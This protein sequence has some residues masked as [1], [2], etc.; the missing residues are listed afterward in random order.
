LSSTQ[1]RQ[2]LA[3]VLG[4]RVVSSLRNPVYRIY[5]LGVL[6]QFASMS[7]QTVAGSLLMYRLTGSAAL[8]GMISLA[9]AIPMIVFS[10]FGGAIADR[11]EKKYLL[12]A[13]LFSTFLLALGIGLALEYGIISQEKEGSWWILVVQS[14][15]M[16]CI[17][18]T[19][20]PARQAIIPEIVS[21]EQTMNAIALN[22]LA[23]NVLSLIGPAIAGFLADGLGFASVYFCMAGF[24]LYGGIMICFIPRTSPANGHRGSILSDIFEG[25]EYIKKDRRILFILIFTTLIVVLSMPFSQLLP[26]FTDDILKVGATGLGVLMSVSGAGALVGSIALA[27]L[28]NKKRGMLLLSAGIVVGAALLVFAFSRSM[29]LSMAFMIFIGLGQTLRGTVGSALLQSYTEP[30]YMGRVMSILMMQWGVMSLVTFGAG[31][32]AEYVQVQWVIGSLSITLLVV[33]L[34]SFFTFPKIRRLD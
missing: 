25:F 26:I 34:I 20:M 27:C 5:F 17:F 14:A 7:M 33:S 31:I 16:G 32:V 18:G 24:N 23:M 3:A 21:R 8:L 6:G 11:I 10:M 1:P 22:W 15:L 13:G 4:L 29:A 30:A 19:M 9:H 28:P 2:N 12:I